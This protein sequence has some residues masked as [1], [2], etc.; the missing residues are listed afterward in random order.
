LKGLHAAAQRLIDIS[1][2]H[3]VPAPFFAALSNPKKLG[4]VL[5][6]LAAWRFKQ[7]IA[8]MRHAVPASTQ[9]RPK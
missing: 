2:P 3:A 6:S 5:A 9:A 1:M 4:S 7:F 8:P